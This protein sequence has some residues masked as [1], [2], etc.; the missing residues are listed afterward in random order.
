MAKLTWEYY[1][2]SKTIKNKVTKSRQ[3]LKVKKKEKRKVKKKGENARQRPASGPPRCVARCR[4]GRR[5]ADGGRCGRGENRSRVG[6]KKYSYAGN[7]TRAAWVKAT[8]P[9][10]KKHVNFEHFLLINFNLHIRFFP[11]V[12][13]NKNKKMKWIVYKYT[14]FCYVSM[15]P[16]FLMSYKYIIQ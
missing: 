14:G 7:R 8:N 9:T 13:I 2:K 15:S 4:P 1:E 12:I 10:L 6:T 16:L 5:S 11:K 3:T